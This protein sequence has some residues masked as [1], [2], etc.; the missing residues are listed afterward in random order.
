[1]V[2]KATATKA[3]AGASKEL[4][5]LQKQLQ[6]DAA[7]LAALQEQGQQQEQLLAQQT[8]QIKDLQTELAGL[9]D[10]L[11]Q[12]GELERLVS[13][14]KQELNLTLEQRQEQW[15][16]QRAK[17]KKDRKSE[18]ESLAKHLRESLRFDGSLEAHRADT[19]RLDE[20]L[21]R[22]SRQ[23][24]ALAKRGDTST[25]SG[26]AAPFAAH[27]M[28]ELEQGALQLRTELE[29]QQGRLA[30]LDAGQQKQLGDTTQQLGNL[31][32]AFEEARSA[33]AQHKQRL[34]GLRQRLNDFDQSL[35]E[36]R[37]HKQLYEQ[38]Y[39]RSRQVL[40]KLAALQ[41]QLTSRH[42]EVAEMQRIGEGRV[43]RQWEKWQATARDEMRNHQISTEEQWRVHERRSQ[44]LNEGLDQ[45]AERV[46][47]QQEL[48]AALIDLTRAQVERAREASEFL[49]R[50]DRALTSTRLSGQRPAK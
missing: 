24:A 22:L 34:T 7:A 38:Q 23:V 37:T 25:T 48:V 28:A 35:E 27:R 2:K 41:T 11:P 19:K 13:D 15:K 12:A 21:L 42:N 47:A 14:F 26:S 36:W 44:E 31:K 46:D 4:K 49:S 10:L 9:K 3:S 6:H 18:T 20:A 33:E 40:E 32:R 16:K 17:D 29:A 5:Q 1:M 8:A 43:K 45:L 50:V 39:Q 30:L